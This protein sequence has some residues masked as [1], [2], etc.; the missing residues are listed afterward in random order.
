MTASKEN[1]QIVTKRKNDFENLHLLSMYYISQVYKNIGENKKASAYCH[2]TL[3][4][5]LVTKLYDPAD[6]AVNCATLSQYHL[7]QENYKCSRHCLGKLFTVT[8]VTI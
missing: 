6:W 1:S 4:Q 8:L 7:T 2:S 3:R 5:Q